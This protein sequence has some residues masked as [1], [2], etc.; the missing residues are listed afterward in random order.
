M[1]NKPAKLARALQLRDIAIRAL[2]KF[3]VWQP[4][5]GKTTNVLQV[6]ID[7]LSV[8]LDTPFQQLPNVPKTEHTDFLSDPDDIMRTHFLPYRFGIWFAREK[9]LSV[10]Y[11]DD[12]NCKLTH[13][14]PGL[15]EAKL[16]ELT[17]DHESWAG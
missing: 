4:S 12:G 15:W 9:A 17:I 11:D 16:E 7:D 10:S 6:Q 5:D 13:F 8:V 1:T 14:Q 2:K 3:G